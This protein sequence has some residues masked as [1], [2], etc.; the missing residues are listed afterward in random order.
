MHKIANE[1]E[2]YETP[3]IEDIP[4]R[5]EEQILAG[6]KTV[7]GPSPG[8]AGQDCFVTCVSPSAS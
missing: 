1:T 7:S 6:C 2:P 5:A 4:L 3:T 8:P